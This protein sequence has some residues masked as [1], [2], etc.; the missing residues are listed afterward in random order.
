MRVQSIIPDEEVMDDCVS[1]TYTLEFGEL[2]ERDKYNW[3][4]SMNDTAPS[5]NEDIIFKKIKHMDF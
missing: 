5:D 1:L 2:H 3:V 4:E